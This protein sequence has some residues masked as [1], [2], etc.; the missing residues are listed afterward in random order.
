[1]ANRP[2]DG[3]DYTGLHQPSLE[4]VYEASK[5]AIE[6]LMRLHGLEEPPE[7][8]AHVFYDELYLVMSMLGLRVRMVVPWVPPQEQEETA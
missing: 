4:E 2:G 1:M 8:C 5:T 3:V 7:D 6:T